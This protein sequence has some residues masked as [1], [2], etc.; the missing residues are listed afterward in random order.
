MGGA[1]QQTHNPEQPGW[2]N[3]FILNISCEKEIFNIEV[4]SI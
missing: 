1:E 4:E 3:S 2:N